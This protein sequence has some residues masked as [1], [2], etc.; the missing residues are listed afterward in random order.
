MLR[1][2]SP[3]RLLPHQPTAHWKAGLS[4][5]SLDRLSWNDPRQRKSVRRP[6]GTVIQLSLET[7]PPRLREEEGA[8][9]SQH[10][11]CPCS[12]HGPRLGRAAVS[13]TPRPRARASVPCQLPYAPVPVQRPSRLC[14][15]QRGS[16]GDRPESLV[17]APWRRREGG[18]HGGLSHFLC[19]KRAPVP[20]V[21]LH[22]L[23]A[24]HGLQSPSTC[25][26]MGVLLT[27]SPARHH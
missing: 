24:P 1:D 27:H 6:G 7:S 12:Q 23:Q 3:V 26:G 19:R 20:H 2:S 21:R 25:S 11:P 10:L 16:E 8:S 22:M 9:S 4:L 15:R 17:R 14:T 18:T 5:L 13:H